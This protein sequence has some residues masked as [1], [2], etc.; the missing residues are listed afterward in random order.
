MTGVRIAALACV[1]IAAACSRG[2]VNEA[3]SRAAPPPPAVAD[4]AVAT[5]ARAEV[6]ATGRLVTDELLTRGDFM[7]Y[8]VDDVAALHY[9]EAAALYGAAKLAGLSGDADRL[10]AVTARWDR[11][12]TL[13]NTANHVDANVVAVVPFELYI[14]GAGEDYLPPALALADGQWAETRAD[15]LTVQTRFWIDDVW[16]IGALQVQAYRATGEA[17]YLDRAALELTAYLDRLQQGN[18]L[19]HHGPDAPFF[20][21]RGNGWVAAGLAELIAELPE[22]HAAYPRLVEGYRAMMAALLDHQAEDGMWRQLIDDPNAWKETSAT[23]MFGFAMAEGVKRGVLSDP[24]YE[25]AYAK[26]WAALQGYIGPDGR[27]SDVCVG[28]GQSRDKQYYLDRPTVTGDLHGQA[29]ILW[30][31]ATL[32]EE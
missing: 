30:F 6:L 4:R 13:P 17:V 31:A 12:S 8:E 22:D 26:A 5:P 28:T 11:A 10:D 19:F 24:A 27:I 14:Q 23:A 21:G 15:G 7:M 20:W 25:E 16:M 9:A 29:P 18:G 1:W 2:E 32:L 3:P